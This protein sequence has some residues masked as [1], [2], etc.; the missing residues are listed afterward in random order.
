MPVGET[1]I[2]NVVSPIG[3]NATTA[4]SGCSVGDDSIRDPSGVSPVDVDGA[5]AGVGFGWGD[6]WEFVTAS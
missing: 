3:I 6:Y 2:G 5:G 4:E 1:R